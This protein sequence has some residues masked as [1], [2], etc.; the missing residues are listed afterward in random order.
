MFRSMNYRAHLSIDLV[1]PLPDVCL[2][3][4]AWIFSSGKIE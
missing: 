3:L 4:Y 2:T 1:L